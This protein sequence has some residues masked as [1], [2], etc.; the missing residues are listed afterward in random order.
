MSIITSFKLEG[1]TPT[2]LSVAD[3]ISKLPPEEMG[4]FTSNMLNWVYDQRSAGGILSLESPSTVEFTWENA[5]LAAAAPAMTEEFRKQIAEYEASA[6]VK[7]VLTQ[8]N[9]S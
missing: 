5:D 2:T 4:L 7:L 8:R 1:Y 3:W 6:G 9:L